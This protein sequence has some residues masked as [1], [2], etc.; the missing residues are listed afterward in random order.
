M[1]LD[2]YCLKNQ[3]GAAEYSPGMNLTLSLNCD[4]LPRS[5]LKGDKVWLYV[6]PDL[7]AD[8]WLMMDINIPGISLE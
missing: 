1:K 4:S 5:L 6:F 2:G 7:K 3:S 8:Y